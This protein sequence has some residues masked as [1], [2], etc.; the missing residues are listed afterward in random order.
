MVWALRPPRPTLRVLSTGG[1]V[2][3]G[4][5]VDRV[6]ALEPFPQSLKDRARSHAAVLG[7]GG[8]R[9]RRLGL[10]HSPK[11]PPPAGGGFRRS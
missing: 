5:R 2:T 11:K 10:G 3:F 7:R 1:Q 9:F 4:F 6:Q 8:V